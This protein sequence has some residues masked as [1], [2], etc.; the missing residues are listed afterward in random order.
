MLCISFCMIASYILCNV[1]GCFFFRLLS[2]NA[3]FLLLDDTIL[4]IDLKN[5]ICINKSICNRNLH[6]DFVPQNS[7]NFH[8]TLN[9]PWG[10]YDSGAEP[11]Y[12]DLIFSSVINLVILFLPLYQ[13]TLFNNCINNWAVYL[14]LCSWDIFQYVRMWRCLSNKYFV[15]VICHNILLFNVYIT[16]S[17]KNATIIFPKY[18]H[19]LFSKNKFLTVCLFY[20]F[21]IFCIL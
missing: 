18:L 9:K 11:N 3:S 13:V 16:M 21:Q 20:I 14:V 19:I 17:T 2:L 15:I 4:I 6:F 1:Q 7:Q 5:A 12:W 8:H 10:P